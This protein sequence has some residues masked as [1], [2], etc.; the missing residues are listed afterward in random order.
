MLLCVLSGDAVKAAI[1]AEA[2]IMLMN[3]AQFPWSASR[4]V[5]V[6]LLRPRAKVYTGD[7]VPPSVRPAARSLLYLGCIL[8]SGI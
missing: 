4:R 7:K 3:L 8:S 1:L 6:Y 2:L 5:A